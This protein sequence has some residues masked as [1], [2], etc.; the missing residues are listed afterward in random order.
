MIGASGVEKIIE[1]ELAPR[2]RKLFEESLS[3]VKELVAA[4]DRIA[5][6]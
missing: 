3:H 6:A 1:V 4:M 5:K 2:E